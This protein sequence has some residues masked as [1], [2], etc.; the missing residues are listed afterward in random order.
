MKKYSKIAALAMT[1]AIVSAAVTGCGGTT[2]KSGGSAADGDAKSYTIGICQ[3]IEHPALDRAT[4]GF[5]DALKEK[6]GEDNVTF[7]LQNAQGESANCSTIVSD[8]VASKVDLIMANATGSL[9]AA[10]AATADIPIV[11]TSV[12]DYATALDIDDWTGKTGRNVTGTS[13]LA[14]LDQQAEMIKEFVPDVSMVGLLY[15]SNEPNSKYQIEE[16]KKALDGMNVEYKEY[17]AADSNEI[18]SVVTNAVAECDALYIPTD[19]TM[20]NNTEIVNNIATPAGVPVI[21][22]EQGICEGCGVATLSIDYYEIGY[23][24]GEMAYDI[25]VNG[26]DPEDMDVQFAKTFTKLYNP[27]I[28]E[29]LNITVPDGYEPIEA[30][31]D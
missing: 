13:D 28:C 14:P 30:G 21:A 31:E 26:S 24:A 12:T 15:C 16:V 19:N 23:T 7:K 2:D 20:A 27:T 6:L 17:S 3:Q 10:A 25:L 9:Q 1:L 11:A 18:Q 22:G 29:K 8:F 4:E 5:Q